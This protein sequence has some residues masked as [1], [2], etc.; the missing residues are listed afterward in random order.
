LTSKEEKK[1]QMLLRWPPLSPVVALL[2]VAA[3][4]GGVAA[5]AQEGAP[6]TAAPAGVYTSTQAERG[7]GLFVTSCGNCHGV[8]FK[9]APERA[10]ALTGDAFL[11]NWEGRNVSNLFAKIKQDMPRNRAGSL[12][13]AVYLDIVAAILQANAYPEGAKELSQSVLDGVPVAAKGVAANRSVPNFAV[14]ETVGCLVRGADNRW[15]L[16]NASEPVVSQDQPL[17]SQEVNDAAGKPLGSDS[18]ELISVVPFKPELADGHKMAAR[19]L[20]YRTSSASR[21][22]VTTLQRVADSCVR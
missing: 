15:T 10:P 18:F 14:V 22:D 20:V 5:F 8:D 3:S 21:L 9:G 4:L 2:S 7:K 1:V 11:K 17:T 13:D 12:T 19:G 16:K 6:A